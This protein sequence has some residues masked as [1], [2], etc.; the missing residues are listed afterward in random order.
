MV[1]AMR[2][3]LCRQAWL[4]KKH[5]TIFKTNKMKSGLKTASLALIIAT[6]VCFMPTQS[7]AQGMSK[8][9]DHNK[10]EKEK[11][12]M[13]MGMGDLKNWPMA[14]Q[15]AAKEQMEKYGKPDEMTP[16][17][18]VWHNNGAWQKTMISSMESKH[19]FPKA[20]TDV[21]EQCISYKVPLDKYDELAMFDGSVT[22]DR[23]QGTIAARC[24]KEENNLLALNLAHDV[25]TGKKSVEEAREAYGKIVSDAMK[26]MKSDYMK[27][28]MF[29][30]DASAPDADMT[31]ISMD[32]MK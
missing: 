7:E 28:L 8:K 2:G 14:S 27:K 9:M 23:T 4:T 15:M 3:L 19:D 25:I 16:T 1:V 18:L 24:D 13:K 21:M 12:N 31:T 29:S 22:V 30:A 26:G 32:K 20:H 5:S 11:G 10:M 6:G 17:M